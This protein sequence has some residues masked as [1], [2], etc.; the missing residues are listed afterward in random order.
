MCQY[1]ST[2]RCLN[3]YTLLGRRRLDNTIFQYMI[4]WVFSNLR[5]TP[6]LEIQRQP[7]SLYNSAQNTKINESLVITTK[8]SRQNSLYNVIISLYVPLTII[9]SYA[10]SL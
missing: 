5:V 7:A 1:R 3:R 4:N 2:T 9:G 8:P 10:G 6:I